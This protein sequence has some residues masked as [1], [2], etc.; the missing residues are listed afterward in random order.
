MQWF[1]G[2]YLCDTSRGTDWRVS[3]LRAPSLAGL[4][5]AV[6][7]TAWFDPLRDE[8]KAYAD[9]LAAAGVATKYHDG[10]GLIH[11]YFGLGEASQSARLEAQRARADFKA[12]LDQGV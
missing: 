9:A 1:A 8:G 12:L 7:C 4:A 5:P 2:H 3:P 11:G 6:V 10:L